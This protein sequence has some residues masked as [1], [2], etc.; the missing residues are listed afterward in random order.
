MKN[1]FVNLNKKLE[2]LKIRFVNL[3]P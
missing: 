2:I 1:R 3:P